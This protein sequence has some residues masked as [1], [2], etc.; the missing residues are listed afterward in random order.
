MICKIIKL[1]T[2]ETIAG[3]VVEETSLY[4]D[5]MR[6]VRLIVAPKKDN[7]VS[8]IFGKWDYTVNFDL[9]IRVFKSGLVSVGEPMDDFKNSYKEMYNEAEK[10]I[11]SFDEKEDDDLSSELE[12]IVKAFSNTTSNTETKTFH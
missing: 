2:G 10:E 9:P 4:I 3:N 8:I 5:V 12:E 7:S 6:P 1:V 11:L